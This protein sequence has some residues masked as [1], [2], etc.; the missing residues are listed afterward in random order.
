MTA[1]NVILSSSAELTG[2]ALFLGF[3][4]LL[5]LGIYFLLHAVAS[6][7]LSI[8]FKVFLRKSARRGAVK[9][10][11]FLI[12][13]S[14]PV[15]FF[16]SLLV[17]FALMVR[18]VDLTPLYEVV[19]H[20]VVPEVEF[21]GRKA[22]EAFGQVKNPNMV[23]YMSRTLH[24]LAVRYLKEAISSEEDEVRLIAFATVSSLEKDLM[25]RVGV[26]KDSLKEAKDEEDIFSI[27]VSLAELYWEFVYLGVSDKELEDFYLS[28]AQKHALEAL[29]IRE[30]P[31]VHFL[32]GRVFLR[33]R[34]IDEAEKHL[35]RAMELGFPEE[36]VATYLLEVY[37]LKRDFKKLFEFSDRFKDILP[38]DPRTASILRVW[39]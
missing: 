36:R 29:Q 5:T 9:A 14:G 18:G 11:F 17:Y 28:E 7:L 25:E 13:L 38:P 3:P 1:K 2:L 12:M 31:K 4:S 23:L 27:H 24:P 35:I 22:G 33:K 6:F 20:E 8:L 10:F 16:V 37:F 30:S 39:A 32:L 26:L 21:E 19:S 15:G 34:M